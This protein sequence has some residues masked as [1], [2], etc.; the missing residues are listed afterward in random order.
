MVAAWRV[1]I[2]PS[3]RIA[4]LT[5]VPASVMRE[6]HFRWSNP[7][8]DAPEV[9]FVVVRTFHG[10]HGLTGW[11]HPLPTVSGREEVEFYRQH[12]SLRER[13]CSTNRVTAANDSRMP[14]RE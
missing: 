14:N 4:P 11:L 13:A 2:S 1:K 7:G 10:R 9:P 5:D 3:P 8:E 6:R 12:C